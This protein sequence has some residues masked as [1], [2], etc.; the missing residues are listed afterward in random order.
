MPPGIDLVSDDHSRLI[1]GL[2][3]E[4]RN[5]IMLNGRNVGPI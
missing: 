4:G 1:L 5:F 3:V 2:T